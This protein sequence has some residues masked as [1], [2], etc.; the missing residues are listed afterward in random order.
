MTPSVSVIIATRN[1]PHLV[2]RLLEAIRAQDWSDF[3]VIVSDDGSTQ[4]DRA[5]YEQLFQTLDHRFRFLAPTPASS[6][7][8]WPAAG[9]NRAIAAARGEFLAFCDDDDTWLRTDHLRV[10]V[11]AMRQAR[12]DVFFA[13]MCTADQGVVENPDWYAPALPVLQHTLLP[14]FTDVYHA[15]LPAIARLMQIR[16]IHMDT[17]VCRRSTALDAGL[18][19]ETLLVGEDSPFGLTLCDRASAILFRST[20]VGEL[21][22][23]PHD[24]ANRRI[25]TEGR[26]LFGIMGY[27]HAAGLLRDA[28]LLKAAQRALSWRLMELGE[29]RLAAGRPHQALH[30][31]IQSLVA[32]PSL[33]ALRLAAKALLP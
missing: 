9:R 24:S 4:E 31:A 22:V 11:T 6:P 10:A 29:L 26:I 15:P 2:G 30:L 12:A 16:F 23:S 18:F 25:D 20:V 17:L 5:T 1:R 14:G 3:E 8:T 7:P 21:D 27:R 33:A 32:W 19:L 13:N 28:G